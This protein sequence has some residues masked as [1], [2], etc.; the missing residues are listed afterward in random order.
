MRKFQTMSQLVA[1]AVLSLVATQSFAADFRYR[2]PAKGVKPVGFSTPTNPGAGTG[3]GTGNGSG[4]VPGGTVT[5]PGGTGGTGGT[6]ETTPPPAEP[7]YA[8]NGV[9]F[10]S[11]LDRITELQLEPG[12]EILVSIVNT[13]NATLRGWMGSSVTGYVTAD[14]SR[15]VASC[16]Q[17]MAAGIPFTLEPGR[18]CKFY[19]VASMK[20][21]IQPE[22]Q[23]FVRG[24]DGSLIPD[25]L[26]LPAP[27]GTNPGGP[28]PP[29]PA[30]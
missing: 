23:F 27:Y 1:M 28:M 12:T 2:I 4:T 29:P 17:N 26:H 8:V 7:T 11:G 16:Q 9:Q 30:D 15:S 25:M 18:G 24:L 20:W 22:D 3:S 10:F 14:L 5:P 13:S 19:L 6:G 21:N